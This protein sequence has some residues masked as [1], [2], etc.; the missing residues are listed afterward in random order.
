MAKH[1]IAVDA[2]INSSPEN[3]YAM[4]TDHPRLDQFLEFSDSV[5]LRKGS[6]SAFGQGAE[7]R[8]VIW[9]FGKLPVRFTEDITLAE[10]PNKF[11]Y[12]V[13]R[14]HIMLGPLALWSG[15]KHHGGEVSIRSENGGSQVHWKSTIEVM[16]PLVGDWLGS[17]FRLE[18]ERI[19]LSILNQ[20]G[21]R[22]GTAETS[23]S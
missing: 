17:R 7:R 10:A 12:L 18:G 20:A 2:F 5:L 8:V 1:I 16:V 23:P 15:V 13:S 6:S 14:A 22:L 3:V 4:L 21:A 11:H 9:M 19:F